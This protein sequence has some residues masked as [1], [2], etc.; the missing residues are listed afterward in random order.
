MSKQKYSMQQVGVLGDSE[1]YMLMPTTAVG[2]STTNQ[3][4]IE[5]QY[6]TD[7]HF[8]GSGEVGDA[9]YSPITV[10][11]RDYEYI[12]YGDDNN[13]PYE[14]QR[15]LRMNMIAQRAQAFN[16]QCCYGQGVR[17]VDRATGK[18]TDDAEIRAFCLRNSVHEIF[19][20]QATDMKFF[21]WNVTVIILSRDHS[22]ILQMRHK[23][24]SYCRFERKRR[25]YAYP[26]AMR[27]AHYH[28]RHGGRQY[29]AR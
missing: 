26:S 12:N 11:G 17:F 9:V 8:L 27:T 6:G 7:T 5:Q 4:A 20:E 19:M 15:L 14:L 13:M 16:V 21:F 22:R 10:N 1:R 28:R 29:H 25:A 23:D 2:G 3:A 24:V 18:D